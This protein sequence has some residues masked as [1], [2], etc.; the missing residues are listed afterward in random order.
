LYSPIRILQPRNLSEYKNLQ[1]LMMLV[2]QLCA[3]M[4]LRYIVLRGKP[5][6]SKPL[7]IEIPQL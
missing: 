6:S 1:P 5:E 2:R 3:F 4:G 7:A